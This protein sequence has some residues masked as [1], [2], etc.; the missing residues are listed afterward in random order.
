MPGPSAVCVYLGGEG[1]GFR[2]LLV[3]SKWNSDVV[4]YPGFPPQIL[5][6][7]METNHE[8]NLG[9]ESLSVRLL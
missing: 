2:C 1:E 4:S 7:D 9:M 6:P 5:S 8:I 3:G